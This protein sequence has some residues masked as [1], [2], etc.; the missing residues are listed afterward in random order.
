[1]M[2]V[3]IVGNGSK[4]NVRELIERELVARGITEQIEIVECPKDIAILELDTFNKNTKYNL[5]L[6]NEVEYKD[7]K[8]NKKPWK[9]SMFFD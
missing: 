7:Y 1:M 6:D 4:N 2:Q 9:K 3:L 5:A 8:R